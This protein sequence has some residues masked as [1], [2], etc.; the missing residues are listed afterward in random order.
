MDKDIA[1][2]DD[3]Y[4][5]GLPHIDDQHKK[6]VS[7]INDLFLNCQKENTV[8]NVV[9]V[10][11]FSSAAEY[12]QTHFRAEEEYLKQAGY[13]DLPEHK[14]EHEAFMTE[15]W[16]QFGKFQK[17]NLAPIDLPRFLKKWLLNHIAVKDKQYAAYI[18][19]VT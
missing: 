19:K 7:M 17:D 15:V 16:G 5:I 6:L 13:P 9:F 12:A 14:K 18:T 11:A 3:A 4:S 10:Q 1:V 2:W 8:K